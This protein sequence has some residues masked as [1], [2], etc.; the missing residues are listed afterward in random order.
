MII[1]SRP[2]KV[3]AY[4]KQMEFVQMEG[5]F[6]IENLKRRKVYRWNVMELEKYLSVKLNDHCVP[7]EFERWVLVDIGAMLMRILGLCPEEPL[8]CEENI[9]LASLITNVFTKV[10]RG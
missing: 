5:I 6:V 8:K 1:V 9:P 10:N 2:K 4:T 7:L 3:S